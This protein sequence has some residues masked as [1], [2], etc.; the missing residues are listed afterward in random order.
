[1]KL[2]LK[3]FKREKVL[4]SFIFIVLLFIL[5]ISR[6]ARKKYSIV[7]FYHMQFQTFYYILV[8]TPIFLYI[9]TN[10]YEL[11]YKH[12]IM[13]RYSSISDWWKKVTK[14]SILLSF[15]YPLILNIIYIA[16]FSIISQNILY[17]VNIFVY[18]TITVIMQFVYYL[19]ICTISNM[20]TY[21]C[22]LKFASIAIISSVLLIYDSARL[23]LN[24]NVPNMEK[25]LVLPY[26]TNLIQY[27]LFFVLMFLMLVLERIL[28]IL[29]HLML[30]NKNIYWSE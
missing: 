1:M 18:F 9:N 20:I 29:S 19:I 21:L 27:K 26:K 13:L 4:Y 22:N 25:I 16:V 6:Y 23:S 30:E 10:I 28:M 8:Y 3:I 11:M 12:R 2:Y 7:S 15:F 5:F 17:S 14:I 24:L